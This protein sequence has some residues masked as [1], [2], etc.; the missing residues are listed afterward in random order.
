MEGRTAKSR[1]DPSRSDRRSHAS[2][3]AVEGIEA[4]RCLVGPVVDP[5]EHAVDRRCDEAA[6]DRP[7]QWINTRNEWQDEGVCVDPRC[8]RLWAADDESGVLSNPP[9]E[10]RISP[11]S[12]PCVSAPGFACTRRS[13]SQKVLLPSLIH[14][15]LY[16]PGTQSESIR[17]CRRIDD[18]T[19][20]GGWVGSGEVGILRETREPLK[21]R[22]RRMGSGDSCVRSGVRRWSW[23]EELNLQPAVYK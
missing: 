5:Y 20:G 1:S 2:E 21:K 18:G 12:K 11:L 19:V 6:G 3:H 16:G 9:S 22:N 10:M 17:G 4:G 8:N 14:R 13:A 7:H 23:R 15:G